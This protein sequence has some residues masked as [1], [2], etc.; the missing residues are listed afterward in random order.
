MT[1]DPNIPDHLVNIESMFSVPD[2]ILTDFSIQEV[3]MVE[4]LRTPGL[5][6]T[7]KAHSYLHDIPNKNLDGWK[8]AVGAL[9][10]TR[11]ILSKFNPP[12][13]DSLAVR[14]RVYRLSN[15]KLINNN[16]EEY[17]INMCDDSLLNDARNLVS[18]PWPCTKPSQV[19]SDVLQGCVGV[20]PSQIDVEEAGPARDYMAENIHPF[21]VVAQQADVALA[22]GNDPSFVHYMTYENYGTHH[23]KSLYNLTKQSPI[24]ELSY[25][26]TGESKKEDGTWNGYRNPKGIMTYSFPCDFDLL[27]DLLNGVDVDG[28]EISSLTVINPLSKEVT[29]MGNPA[30]G[31]GLGGGVYKTAMTNRNTA[32][33]QG[34]CNIDVETYM[35]KRQARMNLLEQDKIAIRL[36]V[37]WNPI[38]NAGKVISVKIYNKNEDGTLL[39]GSGKYLISSMIHNIKRGG[40]STTTMDCVSVTAGQGVL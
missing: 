15:R 22:G 36:T 12:F 10:F 31:C 18:H 9:L 4:S 17:I 37:P 40:F 32:E 25:T 20:D 27:S 35:Q 29:M 34:S 24:I 33:Q 16:N 8:N 3:V 7:I 6:T 13:P 39:Y 23:F 1:T 30:L 5:Q 2:D 28:K 21:Q 38:Y 14:Q 19:V 26:E 11:P